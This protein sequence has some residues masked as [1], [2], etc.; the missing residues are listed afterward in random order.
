[1]GSNKVLQVA[2]GRSASDEYRTGLAEVSER[3]KGNVGLLFTTLPRDEV[4]GPAGGGGGGS[5]GRGGDEVWW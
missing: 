5:G 1:M 2:L 3:L 4:R